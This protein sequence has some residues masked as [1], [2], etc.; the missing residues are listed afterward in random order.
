MTALAPS[1]THAELA[2][3][4]ER[5]AGERAPRWAA[6]LSAIVLLLGVG[7]FGWS[8][9]A[10]FGLFWLENAL[11][12]VFFLLRMLALRGSL[13]SDDLR[14]A[15]ERN[16]R[17]TVEQRQAQ[18]TA[19]AGCLHAIAPAVF[20]LHYGLF[21]AV[22]LSFVVLFFPG[23]S[24]IYGTPSG[25]LAIVA[26]VVPLAI[27]TWR[28]RQRR[29]LDDLPRMVYMLTCYDRVLILH[30]SLVLAG[31]LVW[32]LGTTAMVY[33]LIAIKFAFDWSGRGVLSAHFARRLRDT[34]G[35]TNADPLG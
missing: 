12:G 32:W 11:G 19:A 14:R 17:L 31:V 29:D 22:H 27:D 2:D 25:W 4:L 1:L 16:E 13:V 33:L 15:L 24:A 35:G 26:M 23:W 6:V 9:A 28:F 20:V 10:V 7:Y 18:M 30:V 34:S 21:C 8:A 3:R 5:L